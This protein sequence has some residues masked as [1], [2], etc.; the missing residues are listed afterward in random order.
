MGLV[1]VA[2]LAFLMAY[3]VPELLTFVTAMGEELPIHTQVLIAVSNGFVSYWFVIFG[4]P[5]LLF[6]GGL[7][8]VSTSE[9]ARL[10]LDALKLK[11]PLV[12]PVLKKVVM[13]RFAAYFSIMYGAGITILDCMRVSGD[14]VGN[15]A[16][17]AGIADAG[18][19]IADGK[20]ISEAFA[21]SGLFPRLVIRMLRVG[22]N[23][24]SLED[25]LHNVH[26]FYT[27]DVRESIGRIQELLPVIVTVAM[28]ILVAWVMLSVLGPI[29]DIITQV[30]F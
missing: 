23:T 29:Y 25:A 4:V 27:R 22:E 16:I 20:S 24:G 6:L 14:L 1:V 28:G 13:A 18:R 15:R 5:V 11:L 17:A 10:R 30:D 19:D 9:D 7:V 21:A 8:A 26:Y 2:V 3:V 12:G